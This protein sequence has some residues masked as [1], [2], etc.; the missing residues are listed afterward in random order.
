V[1]RGNY[2]RGLPIEGG[3][4]KIDLGTL[5]FGLYYDSKKNQITRYSGGQMIV[6]TTDFFNGLV[7]E[8]KAHKK[9]DEIREGLRR[10]RG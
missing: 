9:N 7:K 6:F 3:E 2:P 1:W 8:V 5:F 4:M 10:A